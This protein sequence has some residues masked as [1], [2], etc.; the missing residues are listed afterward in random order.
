LSFHINPSTGDV[1]VC[2][3]KKACPFGDLKSDHYSSRE[4]AALAYEHSQSTFRSP[5]RELSSSEYDH[6]F[7]HMKISREAKPTIEAELKDNGDRAVHCIKCGARVGNAVVALFLQEPGNFARC[8]SCST[9]VASASVASRVGITVA[10]NPSSQTYQAVEKAKVSKML[11]Y[12]TSLV[13]N[14]DKAIQ[15][16]DG[17]DRIH[18]GSERAAADRAAQLLGEPRIYVLEV[19]PNSTIDDELHQESENDFNVEA[20]K[21]EDV[22]RY[23]NMYEDS[24]SVSLA[25]KPASVKVIGYRKLTRHEIT[26]M[27]TYNL[28]Q[29]PVDWIEENHPEYLN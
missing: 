21:E 18:L 10:P 12:H 11:W 26:Q 20:G 29:E 2:K 24:G 14:W 27:S 6:L 15:S 1:G 13:E 17:P 5:V 22:V 16:S 7:P 3:A 23:L 25:I 9:M 28:D 4:E 19:S 8:L